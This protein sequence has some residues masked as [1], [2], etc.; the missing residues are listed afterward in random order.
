MLLRR[1]ELCVRLLQF[2]VELVVTAAEAAEG[3]IHRGDRAL[4]RPARGSEDA[5]RVSAS[6]L[7]LIL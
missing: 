3:E 6:V 7:T 4:P 5:R 1:L 2:A